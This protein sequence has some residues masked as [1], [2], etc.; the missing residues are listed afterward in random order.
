MWGGGKGGGR[1][2]AERGNGWGEEEIW[3]FFQVEDEPRL[4]AVLY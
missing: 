4:K 2:S 1:G 3:S